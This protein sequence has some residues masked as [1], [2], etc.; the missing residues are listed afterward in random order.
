MNKFAVLIT[1]YNRK[2]ITL[3]CL[4]KLFSLRNDI[5]VFLVDDSSTDG[6][7][8]AIK[9]LFPQVNL[10]L[11]N[12]NLFWCR[13]MNLAWKAAKQ[14][15]EYHFYFWLNDDLL[16]FD[17]AFE[18]TLSCSSLCNNEAII[19]GLVQG[20]KTKKTIYGGFDLKKNKIEPNGEMIPIS[21]LNGNF[22]LIPKFVFD[23]I[24]FFDDCYHHDIG[25]V[26]YGF[27]AQKANIEVLSTRCFIGTSDE[28]LKNNSL[29][30]RKENVSMRKRFKYLYSPLGA[31]PFIHYHFM[32]KHKNVFSAIM[33][34]IYLHIIN[35][36]P[37][38]IFNRLF[39]RYNNVN[40]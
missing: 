37:D 7:F 27:S 5:D 4:D 29:R 12:G 8:E 22:V 19:S 36:I 26:D 23:K 39:S 13:G 2:Q 21:H 6:T 40:K 10:I 32:N 9:E 15:S 35:I 20:S 30:I 38:N 31:N 34:F 16:L 1:S 18:E 17:N 11:G 33:Y 24:G 14:K 25:D 28:N 3:D